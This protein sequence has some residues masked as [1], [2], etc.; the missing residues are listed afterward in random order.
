MLQTKELCFS[1]QNVCFGEWEENLEILMKMPWYECKQV[2]NNLRW[3]F[4]VTERY[5]VWFCTAETSSSIGISKTQQINLK[6]H[7]WSAL[8]NLICM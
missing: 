7:G 1:Y 8:D 2:R 6:I 4:A 5:C 3:K